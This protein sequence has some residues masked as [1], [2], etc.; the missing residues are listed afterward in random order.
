MYNRT[1]GSLLAGLGKTD[2]P[3][4]VGRAAPLEGTNAFPDPWREASDDFWGIDYPEA[5]AWLESVP[6]AELIVE[7]LNSSTHPV[8]VFVSGNHTNLAEALRLDPGIV[9]HIRAVHIM[10][11]S[12]YVPGNIESDWPDIHND[13]AEWNIW[14]DPVAADEVLASGAP[15]HITPLDATNHVI[16]TQSDALAWAAAGTS[17][18][19]LAGDILQWM[20]DSWFPEG[21]YAWDLVA[22]VNATGAAVCPEVPLSLDILVAPGPDQGRM[23]VVDQA[24]NAIVCLDPDSEQ[25]RALATAVIGR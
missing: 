3:V 7:I 24:P 1:N 6:A 15:L 23:V 22:A 20:L 13:V 17:E 19:A 10:G 14:V 9:D 16:W 5:P 11:G 8:M 12:I 21:V 25:I 4:G 18:G 2:I